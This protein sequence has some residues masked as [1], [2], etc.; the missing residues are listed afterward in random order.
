M[1][2]ATDNVTMR[3]RFKLVAVQLAE[4]QVNKFK[5]FHYASDDTMIQ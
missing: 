5:I 3:R 4:M 2:S 1:D